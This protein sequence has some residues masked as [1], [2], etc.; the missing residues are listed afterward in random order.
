MSLLDY[1]KLPFSFDGGWNELRSR[2]PSVRRTF[3]RLVLPFS[4]LP[5]AMLL[6]A[7]VHHGDLVTDAPLS[8]WEAVAL[9]FLAAELLTVP[10]MGWAIRSIAQVHRLR[11]DAKA[12]FR[13][14]AIA[15]IP[16]WLSSTGLASAAVGPMAGALFAGL[17]LSA[18]VLYRGTFNFLKMDDPMQA[19]ALS[20]QAFAVGGL[21]W[22]FLCGMVILPL[23]R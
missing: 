13:L 3:L 18:A 11:V 23:M 17:F 20:C 15:A 12:A 5:P 9:V 7:G 1:A 2:H 19:Q 14:A 16:M 6:Y 22:A 8:H 10:L 21:V 4:L